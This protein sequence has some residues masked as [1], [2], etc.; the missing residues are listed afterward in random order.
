[1]EAISVDSIFTLLDHGWVGS[2]LGIVGL[3]AAFIFY[4][5]SKRTMRLSAYFSHMKIISPQI[6]SVPDDVKILYKSSEI[7]KLSKTNV[8]LWNSGTETIHGSSVVDDSPLSIEFLKDTTVLRCQIIKETRDVNKASVT[9]NSGN[10][11]CLNFD[12]LD[13]NDGVNIEILHDSEIDP[14]VRGTIKGMPAGITIINKKAP[15]SLIA[16]EFSKLFTKF[17][18]K[19]IPVAMG[20]FGLLLL[21]LFVLLELDKIPGQKTPSSTSENIPLLALGA[22]YFLTP[23][24]SYLM[25]R[26][27]YPKCLN[28]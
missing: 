15:P 27:R 14:T 6:S 13:A 1:M 26:K 10:G 11:I 5:K 21:A 25:T 16:K 7:R 3:A 19:F 8:I 28:N 20:C 23:V 4:I 17:I 22:M 12:F 2:L 24:G 9:T 18:Q